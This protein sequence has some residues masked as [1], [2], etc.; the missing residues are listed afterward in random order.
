MFV[1]ILPYPPTVNTYWRHVGSRTLISRKGRQYRND[2]AALL[3]GKQIE[4]MAGELSV[5]VLVHPPDKRRRDLD[6]I[7]K[8][9]LDSLEHG[10]AYNDDSQISYLQIRR[11]GIVKGGNVVVDITEVTNP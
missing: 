1:C 9:L 6:N 4:P 7:L 2:V 10:G 8:S 11:G 3:A 5:N